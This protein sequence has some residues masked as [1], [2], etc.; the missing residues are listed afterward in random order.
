[1]FIAF[2]IGSIITKELME[3]NIE[4]GERREVFQQARGYADSVRKKLLVVGAPKDLPWG[5]NH[6]AGDVTIDISP[7]IDSK[8]EYKVADVRKIPYPA[9]T[10]GA[11]YISHVLEHL[12]TID[13]AAK[14]LNELHRV[15]DRVFVVSPH[16]SSVS[17]WLHPEHHL[18]VTPSGDGYVIEQRGVDTTKK[19]SYVVSMEIV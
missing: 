4:V 14:A 1:M 5:E 16:K 12:P 19:A 11:A 17:A 6:P 8:H 15:A 3:Q 13:D 2:L 9:G 7:N 10:F 18:W